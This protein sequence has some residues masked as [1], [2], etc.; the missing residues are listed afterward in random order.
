VSVAGVFPAVLGPDTHILYQMP[1]TPH[2][3]AVLDH[4]K[5]RPVATLAQLRSALG[6]SPM[7]V[8]R[9]LKQHGYL[10][11]FNHN[12][13][14]YTLCQTPRF[15]A[16]G[17]WFYRSIGFSRHRTLPKTLVALVD[18]APAGATPEE[19]ARLLRTPVGNLLASLAR[20]RQLARRRLGRRVVYLTAEPQRQQQQWQQRQLPTSAQTAPPSLPD[21]V[22]VSLALPVLAELIRSPGSSAEQLARTL[23]SAGLPLRPQQTQDVVDYFQLEKKEARCR[24]QSSFRT[25]SV[26]GRTACNGLRRFPKP[27]FTPSIGWPRKPSPTRCCLR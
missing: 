20:Q 1:L 3:A 22:P 2:Q 19:L 27:L 6:L 11:S 10:S 21:G 4:F 23:Q 26:T 18:D 15:D 17:L 7:T 24:W 12:A 9:A 13:R 5:H 8:S 14:F 16:N 25:C